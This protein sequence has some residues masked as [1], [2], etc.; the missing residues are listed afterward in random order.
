MRKRGLF[1]LAVI[2]FLV[3]PFN[4]PGEKGPSTFVLSPVGDSLRR[5]RS[6][7]QFSR[8]K[9]LLQELRPIVQINPMLAMGNGYFNLSFEQ[10]SSMALSIFSMLSEK[11]RE[12]ALEE[13][14]EAIRIFKDA[15]QVFHSELSRKEIFRDS[16]IFFLDSL[17]SID[18]D[19][20]SCTFI[21]LLE[22]ISDVFSLRDTEKTYQY[23]NYLGIY[24]KNYRKFGSREQRQKV[25]E[26]ISRVFAMD[27]RA[28]ELLRRE[29]IL[30][31]D[32]LSAIPATQIP[33]H[34][35]A[36]IR[37]I[38]ESMPE[39]IKEDLSIIMTFFQGGVRYDGMCSDI[40]F[41]SA[42]GVGSMGW[43][44]IREQ[45]F[46]HE[47]GHIVQKN[48]ILA[49]EGFK[50]LFS[51]S[52]SESDFLESSNPHNPEYHRTNFM[53]DFADSFIRYCLDSI[54]ACREMEQKGSEIL[55]EKF[56]I[57]V[58]LFSFQ[59][60]G[61]RYAYIYRT[62]LSGKTLTVKRAVVPLDE[63]GIPVIPSQIP[64]E[65]WEVFSYPQ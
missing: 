30:T 58:S 16:I 64:E 23:L 63:E 9:A 26:L 15:V 8:F 50:E 45:V 1:Y 44:G 62:T 39:E 61:K 42:V 40:R 24:L 37:A 22:R 17:A 55:K 21:S 52:K 41:D 12:T 18:R 10:F 47:L 36:N 35:S 27:E 49:W 60:D 56:K 20:I 53:E 43:E 13:M 65:Q 57:I 19:E 38:V 25:M 6:L 2:G 11:F 3:D 32:G 46:I 31:V 59:R 34:L 33:P 5:V 7:Q 54:A 29:F 51:A 4:L 48:S 14:E 28:A